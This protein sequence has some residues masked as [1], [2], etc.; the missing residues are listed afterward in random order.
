[1]DNR[2]HSFTCR[3]HTYELECSTALDSTRVTVREDGAGIG[4][5]VFP[6]VMMAEG[7]ADAVDPFEV[8]ENDIRQSSGRVGRRTAP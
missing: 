8:V 6:I 1:M 5:E 7:V 3:G 4:H 2:Q